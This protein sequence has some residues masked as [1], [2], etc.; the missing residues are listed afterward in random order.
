MFCVSG[1]AG[2]PVGRLAILGERESSWVAD[3]ELVQAVFR[4]D[5]SCS[6]WSS[7]VGGDVPD[8]EVEQ[9]EGGLLVGEVPSVLGDPSELAV[10]GLDHVG[11]VDDPAG[12]WGYSV[13]AR[14]SMVR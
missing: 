3:G 5:G 11:G 1:L 9:F 14:P 12:L 4:S 6:L 8:G 7:S 2:W 10:D 13:R